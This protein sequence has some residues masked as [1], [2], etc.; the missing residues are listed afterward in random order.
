MPFH[1][2]RISFLVLAL[3]Q[4]IKYKEAYSQEKVLEI[5]EELK[6]EVSYGFIKFGYIKF[7]IS[8]SRKEGKKLFII[9]SLKLKLSGSSFHKD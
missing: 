9:Q 1:N 8:N 2:F 6:Y 4:C 5:G 3:I 7:I